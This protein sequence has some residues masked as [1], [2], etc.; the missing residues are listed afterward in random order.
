MNFREKAEELLRVIDVEVGEN[1]YSAGL[2]PLQQALQ[3]AYEK[4]LKDA[5][6]EIKDCLCEPPIDCCC[7]DIDTELNEVLYKLKGE[8]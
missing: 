1:G 4:G 5:V 6:T 3:E 7:Q 2:D 8:K